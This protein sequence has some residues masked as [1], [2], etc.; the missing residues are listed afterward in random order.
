MYN[1]PGYTGSGKYIIQVVYSEGKQCYIWSRDNYT[2]VYTGEKLN[3]ETLSVDHVIPKSMG[4]QCTW[5][6][7]VTCQRILNSNKGS[8]T[9]K[10]AK[11]KLRYTPF[12]PSDGY[13]FN[14]YKQEWYSFV[15]NM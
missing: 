15:A 2:C 8:K 11:L 6:N 5:E 13:Q 9:L 10:E 14:L 1:S 4:G 12:K 3:R 7:L